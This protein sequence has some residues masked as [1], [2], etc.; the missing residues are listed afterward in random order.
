MSCNTCNNCYKPVTVCCCPTPVPVPAPVPEPTCLNPITEMLNE[1][2]DCF[3]DQPCQNQNC[4][5]PVVDW[6]TNVISY[7]TI[8]PL[9]DPAGFIEYFRT[10]LSDGLVLSNQLYCCSQ[11]CEDAAYALIGTEDES[12]ADMIVRVQPKCCANFYGSVSAQ[13]T[14]Y[15]IYDGQGIYPY[16]NKCDNNFDNCIAYLAANCNKMPEIISAGIYETVGSLGNS[17]ICGLVDVMVSASFT[18]DLIGD[19]FLFILAAG[20]VVA[21]GNGQVYVGSV[22]GFQEWYNLN[23]TNGPK[24]G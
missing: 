19:L 7:S 11:C 21:C 13:A 23:N 18:P 10:A 6:L 17:E 4:K 8:D 1:A 12:L 14:L 24:I 15:D 16:P 2:L 20:L 9:Q 22:K 5:S 3:K